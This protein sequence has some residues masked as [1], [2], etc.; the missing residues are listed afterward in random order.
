[1]KKVRRSLAL[2]LALILSISAMAVFPA[3]AEDYTKEDTTYHVYT[4]QGL[5]DVIAEVNSADS[6][7]VTIVLE[8]DIAFNEGWTS[9]ELIGYATTG[10]LPEGKTA[11][12][13]EYVP[14]GSVINSSNKAAYPF[15]GTFDGNGKTVSG[16]YVKRTTGTYAKEKQA[17]ALVAFSTG[18]VV[19]DITL[20]RS[21]LMSAGYMGGI[22]GNSYTAPSVISGV[23]IK[24]VRLNSTTNYVGGVIGTAYK[25]GALTN[26][27]VTDSIITSAAGYAA[28]LVGYS[29]GAVLTLTNVNVDA[30]ISGTTKNGGLSGEV[31]N[32]LNVTNATVNGT[33][34]ATG[35]KNGGL[36]GCL[37][38]PDYTFT[39]TNCASSAIVT[40]SAETG[41][42]SGYNWNTPVTY[43][44]VYANKDITET[45]TVNVYGSRGGDNAPQS[46]AE[47]KSRDELAE[48]ID[49]WGKAQTSPFTRSAEALSALFNNCVAAVQT[50]TDKN[51]TDA[52]R[53]I[54]TVD[55]ADYTNVGLI[56]KITRADG[57]SAEIDRSATTVYTSINANGTKVDVSEFGSDYVYAIGVN[58]MTDGKFI[59]EVTSYVTT[60]DGAVYETGTTTVT[61]EKTGTVICIN[62][63]EV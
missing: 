31:K 33:V 15:V 27:S 1:M 21:A 58:E 57:K 13:T 8:N 41:I 59:F 61:Y 35:K 39:F 32:A 53:F 26:V 43:T 34:T 62:G 30:D 54:A 37:N 4:A 25:G 45:D 56:I 20:E 14:L 55:G 60:V 10:T 47:C 6:T 2:I 36:F 46:T 29:E 52:I 3:F 50:G 16:L 5:L 28:G 42:L 22:I 24:D 19:K 7:G 38:A 63:E 23:S 17:A 44:G 9:D 18:C 48:I 11:A 12:P 49:A 51:G 40:G